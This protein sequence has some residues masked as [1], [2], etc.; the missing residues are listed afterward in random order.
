[1]SGRSCVLNIELLDRPGELV[2]V[3]TIIANLGG[4]VTQVHHE[5]AGEGSDINGC[6]LRIVLETRD[7]EHINSIVTALKEAGYHIL[8][9]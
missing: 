7:A 2:G 8:D 9:N 5:R 4:N 6:Y 3:S 1:M